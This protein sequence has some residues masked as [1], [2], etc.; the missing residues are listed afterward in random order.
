M[1]RSCASFLSSNFAW[2]YLIDEMKSMARR[3]RV[4]EKTMLILLRREENPLN[5]FVSYATYCL[6]A[7]VVTQFGTD[8]GDD[9]IEAVE[10]YR[11]I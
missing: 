5:K 10:C 9:D 11:F 6:N 7:F 4:M 3:S 8:L 2:S 1:R